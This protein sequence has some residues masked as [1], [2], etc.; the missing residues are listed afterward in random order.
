MRESTKIAKLGDMAQAN[1]P[2]VN[3]KIAK[4]EIEIAPPLSEA[5]INR[6]NNV[7]SQEH[8]A[9]VPYDYLTEEIDPDEEARLFE[10]ESAP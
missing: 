1:E 6:V 4:A 10:Q 5:W 8:N 9:T 2:R 3:K 7:A